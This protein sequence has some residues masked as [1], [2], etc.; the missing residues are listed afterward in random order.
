MIEAITAVVRAD[1]VAVATVAGANAR[2]TI[3][4]RQKRL[5]WLDALREAN[6]EPLPLDDEAR[7]E[8][9][10]E[11]NRTRMRAAIDTVAELEGLVNDEAQGEVPEPV[12]GVSADTVARMIEADRAQSL[13]AQAHLG[14]VSVRRLVI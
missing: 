11:D 9:V 6:G 2:S 10:L 8:A 5:R 4:G 12:D 14:A 7:D 1:A 13:V 3:E